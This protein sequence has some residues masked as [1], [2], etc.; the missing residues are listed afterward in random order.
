MSKAIPA[1]AALVYLVCGTGLHAQSIQVEGATFRLGMSREQV[2]SECQ[3]YSVIFKENYDNDRIVTGPE[4]KETWYASVTFKENRLTEVEKY[5]TPDNLPET[6][7][8]ITSA[9]YGA[10]KSATRDTSNCITSTY[11][12]ISPAQDYR[13]TRISCVK[14]GYYRRVTVFIKIFHFSGGDMQHTSVIEAIEVL[15]PSVKR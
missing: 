6:A 7:V 10:T 4:E 2:R 8:G 12:E 1:L 5:W 15:P 14:T 3:K 11:E 13:H 9:L